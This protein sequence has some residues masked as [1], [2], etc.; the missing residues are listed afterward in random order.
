MTRAAPEASA[1]EALLEVHVGGRAEH[2][3]VEALRE[4]FLG[5]SED[6]GSGMIPSG[7]RTAGRVARRDDLD[8]EAGV[9]RD[10]RSVEDA[11]REAVADDRRADRGAVSHRTMLARGA[12]RRG[13]KKGAV[14]AVEWCELEENGDGDRGGDATSAWENSGLYR[15]HGSLR[16]GRARRSS[17]PADQA[18]RAYY[19]ALGD[20]L[21]YG[22]QPN[23]LGLPPSGFHT[24]YV[25]V[26]A[27]RLRTQAPKI[28]VVN[29]GC[30]G[31][32]TVTFARGGCPWL[33]AGS[34][35]HQ[36][37]HGSQMNAALAFLAAHR[38]RVSPITLTLWSNDLTAFTTACKSS[39]ACERA[40]APRE[41]VAFASR[42]GS[43]LHR[44]RG[45]A[46][47]AEIIVTGAW[48]EDVDHLAQTNPLYRALDA[49]I[50]KAAAG[51]GARF[52]DTLPVFNPPGSVAKERARICALTFVCSL[53]DGHPNDARVSS[54]GRRRPC[55]FRLHAPLS[56]RISRRTLARYRGQTWR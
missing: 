54:Y 1:D 23:K 3:E 21:S 10:E 48:S 38:G 15:D 11:P 46:P 33:V 22:V 13:R 43:I 51:S 34:P 36:A 19:L 56:R 7:L 2:D 52:A 37:F 47:G 24:G 28:Q 9:G 42:L 32:S 5:R 12:L 4:Q 44:L 35:L 27:A 49:A 30:P 26:F 18:P 45:A 55:R 53:G 8:R 16:S 6:L 14:V 17:R 20:S 40:R 29:Y 31:E 50:A 25:D 41:L 39:L